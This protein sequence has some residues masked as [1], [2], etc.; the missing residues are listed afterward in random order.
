MDWRD[1]YRNKIVS[2]DEAVNV[3]KSGDRVIVNLGAEPSLCIRA[4]ADRAHE[5][6]N[7][8]PVCS[9]MYDYPLFHPG[10]EQCFDVRTTFTTKATRKALRERHISWIPWLP[11]LGA[12]D[13]CLEQDRGCVQQH[14]DVAFVV[15]TPPDDDGY[16]SFG[17][18]M[19]NGPNAVKTAKVAVAQIDEKMPWTFGDNVQV[20]QINYLVDS[21]KASTPTSIPGTEWTPDTIEEWEKEQV[22]ASIAANLIRDGD[23]LQVG[24]G[25]PSESVLEY[26]DTRNDLGIDTEVIYPSAVDL[27]KKGVITGAKKNIN[28]AKVIATAAWIVEGHPKE[29][30]TVE[31]LDRNPMFEFHDFSYI[32]NIPRIASNDNLVAVNTILG[33]DLL[34]QTIV[35]FFGPFPIAGLGGQLEYCIGSHYSQGGRSIACLL[36]YAKG[37]SV[38]RIVPQFETGT[39]IGVPMGYVD[40]LVTEYGMVNLEYKTLRERAEAIISVAHP[41]FRDKLTT[42]ARKLFWP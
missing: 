5:L 14:A 2:A 15:V 17:N 13:R 39:G 26:L 9:W 29:K 32:C 38:S 27:I 40:Y 19:W 31:F 20:S 12:R 22:I 33:I 42:A 1:K 21:P 25:T 18:Q 37:G 28:K 36:S 11:G 34:G 23:T 41:E 6:R 24:I 7:V 3:V 10:F 35:D 16:C 4:L 8:K 30:E